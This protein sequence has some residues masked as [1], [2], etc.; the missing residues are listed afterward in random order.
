[1]SSV[2]DAARP[3]HPAAHPA[4]GSTWIP[5]DPALARTLSDARRQLHH[6]VQLAAAA[7]ISYLPAR[8]DDSHTNLEWVAGTG[9]LVSHAIPSARDCRLGVAIPSLA[10]V[11]LDPAETVRESFSLNGRTISDAEGW[12]RGQF[13]A[14]GA[15]PARFTRA[16]H[17]EI[18]PHPVG[19]GKAFDAGESSELAELSD[20]FANGASILGEIAANTSGASSVRCWPHHFDIATLIDVARHEHHDHTIGIGMDPGDAYY[21]EPYLYVN[22]NPKPPAPAL[23]MPLAGGGSWHTKEWIGAVLPGSRLVD[24]ATDQEQEVRVFLKSARAA[25]RLLLEGV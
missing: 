15:D 25:C 1:M 19:D 7:G 2:P 23:V 11:I 17:F 8:D 21:D 14:L 6:A 13:A 24:S 18:P 20:W 16:R 5:V 3:V 22:L 4:T 12:I 9:A 10:L